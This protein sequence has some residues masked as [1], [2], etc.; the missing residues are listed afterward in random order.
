MPPL[1]TP[2][3]PVTTRFSPTSVYASV[4]IST[5]VISGYEYRPGARGEKTSAQAK[6]ASAY[7]LNTS[8]MSVCTA[9]PNE[10][11]TLE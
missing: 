1:K 10:R 8:T 5:I 3:L 4:S 11:I 9:G 2:G 7:V 6:P